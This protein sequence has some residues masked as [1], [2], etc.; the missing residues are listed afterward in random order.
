MFPL[1]KSLIIGTIKPRSQN[2]A[3]VLLHLRHGIF[4]AQDL[5][6]TEKKKNKTQ[7][8]KNHRLD[9]DHHN[10]SSFAEFSV[11]QFLAKTGYNC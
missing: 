6:E 8:N 7:Y 3:H 2:Q 11:M 10:A 4:T 5:G 9:L 1:E